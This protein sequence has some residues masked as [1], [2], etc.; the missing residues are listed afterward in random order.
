MHSVG[1]FASQSMNSISFAVGAELVDGFFLS[2]GIIRFTSHLGF[3]LMGKICAGICAK[4]EG[5]RITLILLVF[6]VN[7]WYTMH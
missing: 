4:S 3:A 1:Q 2:V 7:I 5:L 6:S